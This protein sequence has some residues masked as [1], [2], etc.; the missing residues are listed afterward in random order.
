MTPVIEDRECQCGHFYGN[1][2]RRDKACLHAE[3]GYYICP[4]EGYEP[5]ADDA[6]PE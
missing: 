1:H 4:C 3:W 5:G 6:V 2:G